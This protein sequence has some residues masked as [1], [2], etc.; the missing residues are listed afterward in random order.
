MGSP[1]RSALEQLDESLQ[2]IEDQM[3]SLHGGLEVTENQLWETMDRAQQSATTLRELI[4]EQRPDANWTNREDLLLLIDELEREAAT[5]VVEARRQK[6]IDLADELNAGTIKHRFEGRIAALSALRSAAVAELRDQAALPEPT[7][8][9]PGP[10]APEWIHWACNLNDDTDAEAFAVLR[11]GFPAL[12]E[13]AGSMEENFWVPSQPGF[14]RGTPPVRRAPAAKPAE[15]PTSPAARIIARTTTP[16]SYRT[17]GSNGSTAEANRPAAEA[18]PTSTVDMYTVPSRLKNIVEKTPVP[19]VMTATEAAVEKQVVAE[20]DVEEP[21]APAS[22]EIKEVE[23]AEEEVTAASE[24]ADA[25]PLVDSAFTF[26]VDPSPKKPVAMWIAAGVVGAIGLGFVGVH[27]FGSGS[28]DKSSGAMAAAEKPGTPGSSAAGGS[29]GAANDP[30]HPG[31][32]TG[33]Q[34]IEGAQHQLLLNVEQCQRMAT[35]NVECKGYVTNL[36]AQAS[37]VTLDGVDVVDGKGNSFNLNSNGQV[38]F[39][40][41]RTSSIAAGAREAYTVKVPDK[42]P[43]AKTLTLYVDVNNPHGWEYTFRDIPIAG[44]QARNGG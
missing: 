21:V 35:G 39:S 40:T 23:D 29:T 42:D 6:L 31:S 25:T 7:R 43:D 36:S 28:N 11:E 26:G 19:P 37:R 24:S 22:A 2:T 38:N 32:S 8:D 5:Q 33:R 9:L 44:D 13:F 3:G 27:F 1:F 4:Y 10:E 34:P 20:P 14:E 15:R 17:A 12:E 18:K 41:G 30:A 16:D